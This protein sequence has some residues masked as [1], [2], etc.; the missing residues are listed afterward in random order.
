MSKRPHSD[1]NGL[2]D[3]DVNDT[4]SCMKRLECEAEG[5]EDKV[6]V[7]QKDEA[8]MRASR[9]Q[10]TRTLAGYIH[11]DLFN[12]IRARFEERNV[13]FI[14]LEYVVGVYVKRHDK[15]WFTH[16]LDKSMH[17]HRYPYFHTFTYPGS[18]VVSYAI[19]DLT[20]WYGC[21]LPTVQ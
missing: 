10:I 11:R 9:A 15:E 2:V 12:L 4:V 5:G 7:S 16:H 13:S 17:V 1:V 20:G 3:V 21:L 6:V 14:I 8:N 18:S 19:S